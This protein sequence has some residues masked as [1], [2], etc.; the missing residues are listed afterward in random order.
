LNFF[1]CTKLYSFHKKHI[2]II[3]LL[4]LIPKYLPKKDSSYK[5]RE[6]VNIFLYSAGKESFW[7]TYV[8]IN[9]CIFLFKEF[10]NY[11]N[12]M[13]LFIFFTDI[14]KIL[15]SKLKLLT[16]YMGFTF[17]WY[18]YNQVFFLLYSIKDTN[19]SSWMTA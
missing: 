2:Y 18:T 11:T 8:K 19:G 14:F 13:S 5:N 9:V 4:K 15:C 17:L 6:K 1:I 16:F 3:S 12:Y 10:Q 7:M